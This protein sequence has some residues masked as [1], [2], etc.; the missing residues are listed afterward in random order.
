MILF[1]DEEEKK[2]NQLPHHDIVFHMIDNTIVIFVNL[3]L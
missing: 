1:E 3:L 2:T